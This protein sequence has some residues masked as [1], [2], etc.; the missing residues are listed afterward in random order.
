M[1]KH[2]ATASAGVTAGVGAAASGSTTG[3]CLRNRTLQNLW[4]YIE[5]TAPLQW[6]HLRPGECCDIPVGN[7]WYTVGASFDE[8]SPAS[9]ILAQ[10]GFASMILAAV[11]LMILPEATSKS[12]I[13]AILAYLAGGLASSTG[14][15]VGSATLA[16]SNKSSMKR[17]GVRANGSVMDIV[18]TLQCFKKVKDLV[19]GKDDEVRVY[20]YRWEEAA[21]G[22][23]DR[24]NG[25]TAIDIKDKR[26]I[27]SD[28]L[29]PVNNDALKSIIAAAKAEE[30]YVRSQDDWLK[31]GV[32]DLDFFPL[33]GNGGSWSQITWAPLTTSGRNA[34]IVAMRVAASKFID[35]VQVFYEG[36]STWAPVCGSERARKLGFFANP[37]IMADHLGRGGELVC[38]DGDYI[39]N[40]KIKYDKYVCQIDVGTKN[41]QK[42]TFGGADGDGEFTKEFSKATGWD[43][44]HWVG[45][46]LEGA[47]WVDRMTF[48][49]EKIKTA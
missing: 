19:T 2:V 18:S 41:G 43:N 37:Q 28:N 3:L 47:A 38:A 32:V 42:M 23:D 49:L 25:F 40:I 20:E 44:F 31:N 13:P 27:D 22:W 36:A 45:F 14:L 12:G 5:Q 34:R 6:V 15:G 21:V 29:T 8:P 7:V 4:L 35:A 9:T 1:F 16:I 24:K 39:N 48:V 11:V 30:S 26:D 46:K 33:G 17:T 10:F